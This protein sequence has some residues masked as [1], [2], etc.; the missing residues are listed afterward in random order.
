M[1][2]CE[3]D[4]I[5][6]RDRRF[7]PPAT[8]LGQGNVFTGVCDSV[9]KGCLPQCMLGYHPL[10]PKDQTRPP[11]TR[12]QAP[13]WNRHPQEQTPPRACWE[14][15]ST[16]GRYASYWNAILFAAWITKD[17]FISSVLA[18]YLLY[19]VLLS[20]ELF[21]MLPWDFPSFWEIFIPWFP[22]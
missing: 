20:E 10:P 18:L 15:R 17:K 1:V 3:F 6:H 21:K 9:N 12:D 7:L 2:Y 14:I 19:N 16:S 22:Q 4:L 13:P 11:P 8:K 5:L